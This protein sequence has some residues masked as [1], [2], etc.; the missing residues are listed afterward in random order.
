[1]T[2]PNHLSLYL[3]ERH[4][5]LKRITLVLENDPRIVAALLSGS[6]GRD[7]SDELSDL[8]V[9]VVSADVYLQGIV[10]HRRQFVAQIDEPVLFVEAP[11]NAPEAGGYLMALYDAPV[12]PHQV[13]WYWQPLSLA[14]IPNETLLL[15]DRVGL[16]SSGRPMVYGQQ[17]PVKEIIETPFHFISFFWA[18][19]MITLKY[20]SRY[21]RAEEMDMLPHLLGPIRKAGH[22][23]GRGPHIE[24]PSHQTPCLKLQ[25]LRQLARQMEE[26]MTEVVEGGGQVPTA[27][28]PGA[29]RFL[30][31][32]ERSLENTPAD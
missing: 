8:D 31:L 9:H 30:D 2:Q 16:P 6:L 21:P 23:V 18:M 13:D 11:Q 12:A 7:D 17:S 32:V 25:F 4:D 5:L 22:F 14:T 10:D 15:F 26:F 27:I 1:M 24:V 20:V 28:I 19:F 29:Y 3:E